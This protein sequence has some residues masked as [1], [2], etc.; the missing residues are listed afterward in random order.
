LESSEV[1]A[2]TIVMHHPANITLYRVHRLL[3]GAVLV[4]LARSR[5]HESPP[6]ILRPSLSHC[7]RALLCHWSLHGAGRRL[8]FPHP[9]S[10]ATAH[11]STRHAGS[12]Y[13]HRQ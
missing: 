13:Q 12:H 10:A 4:I 5:V 7:C 1:E 11:L 9:A 2:A 3:A 6:V 8:A